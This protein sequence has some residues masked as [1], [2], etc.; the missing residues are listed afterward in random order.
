MARR[1]PQGE[2][3]ICSVTSA[4]TT[5][6]VSLLKGF[7][8]SVN[9]LSAFT[10]SFAAVTSPTTG[11]GSMSCIMSASVRTGAISAR[12]SGG[13]ACSAAT[14]ARTS[15]FDADLVVRAAWAGSAAQPAVVAMAPTVRA[16]TAAR[17]RPPRIMRVIFASFR[18][19]GASPTPLGNDGSCRP[20][21][22]GD[23]AGPVPVTSIAAMTVG[24]ML[25]SA[26][27]AAVTTLV[28]CRRDPADVVGTGA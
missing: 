10:L 20:A 15:V 21:R 17:R 25:C 9:P 12:A 16:A 23:G 3:D 5:Q 24:V 19:K 14:N 18:P 11:T 2:W 27:V 13:A 8:M 1:A 4:V 22:P 6:K 28:A 26:V 7:A